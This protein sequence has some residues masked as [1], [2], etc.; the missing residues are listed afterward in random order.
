M[1]AGRDVQ[2]FTTDF[3]ERLFKTEANMLWFIWFISLFFFSSTNV[4]ERRKKKSWSQ[5]VSFGNEK[6]LEDLAVLRHGSVCDCWSKCGTESGA[7]CKL[8][9][10][11]KHFSPSLKSFVFDAERGDHLKRVWTRW[12]WWRKFFSC[13]VFRVL[14]V[15]KLKTFFFHLKSLE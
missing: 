13:E 1:R 6:A 14:E 11:F 5:Q 9:R 10:V 3:S 15:E 4:V 8:H 7:G 2:V 12:C